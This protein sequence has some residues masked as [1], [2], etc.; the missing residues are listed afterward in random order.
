MG[1]E[2]FRK[3]RNMPFVKRGM[4][5][6]CTHSGKKGRVSGT[7]SSGNL[8]ITFDGQKFSKNHHPWWK[9]KYFDGQGQLIKEYGE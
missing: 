8:N 7:N 2:A 3:R 6:E 5:V 4:R 1:M 9:M